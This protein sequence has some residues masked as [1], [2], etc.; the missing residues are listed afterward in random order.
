MEEPDPL[1]RHRDGNRVRAHRD[2]GFIGPGPDVSPAEPIMTSQELI[3][4]IL[5]DAAAG[6]GPG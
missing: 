3:E 2:P 4:E 6:L 5:L 1:H